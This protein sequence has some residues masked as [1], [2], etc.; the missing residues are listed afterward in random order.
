M[1]TI[2][3]YEDISEHCKNSI[4][5]IQQILQV[6][7]QYETFWSEQGHS[8]TEFNKYK[9]GL[10]AAILNIE[11]LGSYSRSKAAYMKK[12]EASYEE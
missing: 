5:Y 3:T 12:I 2:K 9:K 10:F 4:C 8:V 11:N 7:S 6:I 1:D